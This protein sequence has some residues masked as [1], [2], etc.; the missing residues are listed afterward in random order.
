MCHASH[1]AGAAISQLRAPSCCSQVAAS[2]MQ[3]QEI[4]T[5]IDR[6]AEAPPP[7]P[8]P[9][10]PP[11]HLR[12]HVALARVASSWPEGSPAAQRCEHALISLSCRHAAHGMSA[13][14]QGIKPLRC[15]SFTAV[16]QP[17]WPCTWMPLPQPLCNPTASRCSRLTACS[18][19]PHRPLLFVAAQCVLSHLNIYTNEILGCMPKLC[20][21]F[22][23]HYARNCFCVG[24]GCR[25]CA[26][27]VRCGREDAQYDSVRA[28]YAKSNV[29]DVTALLI[30]SL[31]TLHTAA[32]D[33][34]SLTTGAPMTAP[35]VG[36]GMKLHAMETRIRMHAK[37]K[38][39][40]AP[41]KIKLTASGMARTLPT[42]YA[43]C[44]L[45]KMMASGVL[46]R[47][48]MRRE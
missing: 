24:V 7:P 31:T 18:P 17:S 23:F 5:Q 13:R 34:L 10:P 33:T 27:A 9:P 45:H 20:F 47:A 30:Q 22:V 21:H 37:A 15:A 25:D 44:M 36:Q 6:H 40:Y 41:T 35:T 38:H 29:L 2:P 1:A 19:S 11:P 16:K 46:Q 8:H 42:P 12:A 3:A 48:R 43:V 4:H 39:A 26:T 32:R 14:V 28:C